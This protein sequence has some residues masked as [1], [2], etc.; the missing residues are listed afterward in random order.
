VHT[1]SFASIRFSVDYHALSIIEVDGTLVTPYNVTGLTLAVAQRYSVLLKTDN[2][3][4]GPFWMRAGLQS[5]MFTYDEPGQNLDIRGVIRYGPAANNTALPV[6]T[7][8]PGVP[9]QSS[10]QDMDTSLLVPAV[11]AEAPASTRQYPL[12][13]ALELADSLLFLGFMNSTSWSPLQGTTTLL[14]ARAALQAGGVYGTEGGSLQSGQQFMVTEDSVQV[15]DLLISN[16][17]DGDHPFHLHGHRPW[18]MSTG[19]GRYTGEPLNATNP[20]RRD[21]FLIPAYSW[22]VIRFVTDN[23]GMWAF[24]CHLAW[25]MAAGLLMQV[26]SLPTKAAQLD[27]PQAIVNQCA[28]SVGG[29]GAK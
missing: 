3:T 26:N 20:L 16:L 6:E 24:H 5:D 8:D 2:S 13:I 28:A 7:D 15:V 12:T 19:L 9:S 4:G 21:T 23:P 22:M 14:Q 17:D 1:G 25:H 27:I 10:L 29:S 18:I 11:V